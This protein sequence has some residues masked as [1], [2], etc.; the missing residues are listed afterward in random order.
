MPGAGVALAWAGVIA[1]S[2]DGKLARLTLNLSDRMGAVEHVSAV[3]AL[4][5]WLLAFGGWVSDWGLL[6]ASAPAVAT[7]VLLACFALDKGVSGG[8]RQ[9]RRQ[10]DLRLRP[11]RRPVPPFRRPPQ[12]PPAHDDPRSGRGRRRS[13]ARR[14]VGLD[15]GDASVSRA[16]GSPGDSCPDREAVDGERR[17]V[18][19]TVTL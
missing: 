5:L 15:G 8:F 4:G 6:T 17:I 1:D 11:R 18:S 7:W 12:H 16:A 2:V 10:G 14:D 9:A 19:L 13:R 3:P